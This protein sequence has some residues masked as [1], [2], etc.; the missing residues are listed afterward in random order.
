MTGLERPVD[1]SPSIEVG[2]QSETSRSGEIRHQVAVNA[3]GSYYYQGKT[4][5]PRDELVE[6]ARLIREGKY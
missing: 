5:K 4:L 1:I 6:K 2:S 3:P